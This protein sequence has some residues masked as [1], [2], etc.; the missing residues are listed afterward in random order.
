LGKRGI[1]LKRLFGRPV[2]AEAANVEIDAEGR[3]PIALDRNCVDPFLPDEPL[4]NPG[5][6]PI[7]FVGAVGGFAQQDAGGVADRRHDVDII[8]ARACHRARRRFD[9]SDCSGLCRH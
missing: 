7:I 8:L 5:A 6:L 1:A 9:G 2:G 4:R 3:S